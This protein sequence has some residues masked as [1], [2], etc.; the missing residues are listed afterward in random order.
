MN[1]ITVYGG[2][3]FIGSKFFETYP[4]EVIRMWKYSTDLVTTSNVLN[5]I[6][7]VDNYN[8]YTDPY[9]D[10][11][12]NLNV[13]LDLLENHRKKFG[14]DFVFNQISSWFVYGAQ[15]LP[16]PESAYC[17]PTGFYSITKR[18]SEQL[19]ISYCNTYGIKYRILRLCGVLGTSD[20]KVSKKK[21]AVQWLIK[22]IVEGKDIDLYYDG[23]F[24]RDF[25][26]VRDVVRAI[27]LILDK[28][29]LNEIYN[30]G[31]GDF[32]KF[33]RLI[34][35]VKD[36]I[37]SKS[38]INSIADVPFHGN[39]QAKNMVLDVTKLKSLGFE[40][41]HKIDDTICDI[42]RHYENLQ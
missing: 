40:P 6:S 8:V 31:S 41:K 33:G 32:I 1:R 35:M 2:H 17:N 19:L 9:L 26:D 34:H 7:T 42:A 23:D 22:Q 38:K 29:E 14:S 18:T 13:L 39:V 11:D 24:F 37:G 12:T 10:I 30:V 3:G 27:K 36:F 16:V 5:F 25:L 15:C 21:N 4:D 20:K 28:G